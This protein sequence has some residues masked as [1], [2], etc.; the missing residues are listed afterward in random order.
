[1]RFPFGKKLQPKVGGPVLDAAYRLHRREDIARFTTCATEV[2]PKKASQIECFG[3]DWMGRQFALDR[4]RLVGGEPQVALLDPETREIYEIPCGYK[5]FHEDELDKHPNETVE[6]DRFQKW[7]SSG[8][9]APEY[10]ECVSF[11]T[12]L[13]LGGKDTFDNLIVIDLEVYR[14]INGQ[15]L[16]QIRDLPKGTVVSKFVISD[17]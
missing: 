17:D 9:Q 7:L 4:S 3:A 5:E 14:S 16:T 11:K 6:Y 10:G 12:P 15:I 8:G 2:F 13:F 1:M